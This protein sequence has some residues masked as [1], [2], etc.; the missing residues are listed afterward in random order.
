[1]SGYYEFTRTGNSTAN[2]P[3]KV[4]TNGLNGK[5]GSN[6]R[7]CKTT[8]LIVHTACI[9]TGF[10]EKNEI[11]FNAVKKTYEA[12]E[13][14]NCPDKYANSTE[15]ERTLIEYKRFLR[16]NRANPILFQIIQK[17]LV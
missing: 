6:G 17:T 15:K 12:I 10:N 11:T 4:Q 3:K 2:L 5:R 16:E 9:Y 1:M 13:D 14:P 7:V 8:G